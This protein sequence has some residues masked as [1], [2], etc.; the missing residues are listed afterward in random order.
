MQKAVHV[1]IQLQDIQRFI[2]GADGIPPLGF[3]HSITVDFYDRLSSYHYPT[4]A[5]LG[6]H[7]FGKC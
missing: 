2:T 3:P 7:G 4:E 1:Y 5:V 6:A